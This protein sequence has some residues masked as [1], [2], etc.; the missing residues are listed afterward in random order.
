MNNKLKKFVTVILVIAFWLAVWEIAAIIIDVDH[1]L[2]RV[3]STFLAFVSAFNDNDFFLKVALSL[4]RV[5]IGFILGALLSMTFAVIA[6]KLSFI[7]ALVSPIMT[8]IK[9]APVAAIVM[10]LW[11]MIGGKNV[12]IAISMLM[13]IPIVWQNIIDGYDAID[14]KLAEVC[15]IYNFSYYK[16]LRHLILPTLARFLFPGLI[17]AS[18]LAFKA[19]IAAEIICWTTNSIG[20]EIGIAKANVEGPEMFAWVILVVLLSYLLESIIKKTIREIGRKCHL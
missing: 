13:V 3:E 15:E 14:P 19:G 11:V 17:T 4:A 5:L 6:T 18:G 8:V 1:V 10:I 7:K 20:K 9:S 16:R 12:P 2:P